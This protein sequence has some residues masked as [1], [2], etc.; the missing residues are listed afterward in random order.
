MDDAPRASER[1]SAMLFKE[2]PA[3]ASLI[4]A[5]LPTGDLS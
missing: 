3:L 4:M 5:R 2:I 1:G